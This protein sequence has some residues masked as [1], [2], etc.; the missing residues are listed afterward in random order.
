VDAYRTKPGTPWPKGYCESLDGGPGDERLNE[1]ESWSV[2]HVLVVR[3][4]F[5]IEYRIGHLH[6]SPGNMMTAEHSGSC[7][8]GA[9]RPSPL[10]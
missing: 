9:A 2:G 6:G 5:R 4:R 10:G 8:G 3:E 1:G 7:S